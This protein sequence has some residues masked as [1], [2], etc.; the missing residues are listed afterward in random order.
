[1]NS[2]KLNK[3][4]VCSGF[5]SGEGFYYHLLEY[6]ESHEDMSLLSD[7]QEYMD[8]VPIQAQSPQPDS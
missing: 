3:H 5:A 8:T 6:D 1:M 2:E 4:A 7:P